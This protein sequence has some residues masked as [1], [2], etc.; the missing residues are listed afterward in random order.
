MRFNKI[1]IPAFGPFTQLEIELPRNDRDFHLFYGPNEAGK[2]S[3]L[4]SLRA[5]LFGI[6]GQSKDVF[7]HSGPQMRIAAELEKQDGTT[8]VFQRRKGNKNTLL[9]ANDTPLAESE[10]QQFLGGVDEAYFDSMFGLGSEELRRGADALLRGEGRL[11]EALFSASLGGTPVDKVI[12]SLEAEAASLFRGRASSII[13]NSAAQLKD[14]LKLS[15]DAITKPETWQA[16]QT[17]LAE[18]SSERSRLLA[19]KQDLTHRKSWLERC[20]D[21]FPMVGQLREVQRQLAE[22]PA[23]PEL[24]ETFASEVREARKEW[25][26]A[27]D[28]LEPLT[29]QLNA[30]ISQ[31][32]S[33]ILAPEVLAVAADIARL[34]AGIGVY[35]EQQLNLADKRAEVAQIRQKIEVA[36]RE[37]EIATP[38]SELETCRISQVKLL[39]L[40]RNATALSTAEQDLRTA[41]E[42]QRAL[43]RE[44]AGLQ[45]QRTLTETSDILEIE[46]THARTKSLEETAKGL[47]ARESTLND[48]ARTLDGLLPLLRVP[49]AGPEQIVGLDV[50]L[51]STIEKFRDDFADL[52]RE[53]TSLT[54][55]RSDEQAKADKVAAEIDH[56]TRQHDLPQLDDLTAARAHRER[57][58]Q[59]LLEDWKGGGASAE[60]VPGV[61]LEQAYPLA[62]AAADDVADRLRSDADAVA[63]LEQHRKESVLAEKQLA[64]IHAEFEQL[65]T[66]RTALTNEW[67]SSWKACGVKPLSAREMLEW[68]DHWESFRQLWNQWRSENEKLSSDQSA[69]TAAVI[70]LKAVLALTDD[71][72]ATLLAAARDR[73]AA[74]HQ[75]MGADL[76]L[77]SQLSNKEAELLTLT[78]TIPDLTA[79]L[80]QAHAAWETCREEYA[81]PGTLPAEVAIG[82]LR[83]RKALF[84]DYDHWRDLTQTSEMLETKVAAYETE[85]TRV[86]TIL[87][88]PC[89]N[90][91]TAAAALSGLLEEAKSSQHRH[92]SLQQRIEEIT[93]A[94]ATARQ[95]SK[96][97]RDALD[98]MLLTASLSVD[99]D[100]EGFL[101][102]LENRQ[103]ISAHLRTLRD[104]LAG[105]ARGESVE[106][107]VAKVEQEN[108]GELDGSL[109][110]LDAQI[111][112]LDAAIESI[113]AELHEANIQLKVI[114]AASDES[115]RQFQLAEFAAARIR[116]DGERFARLQLALGLLRSRID[117]FREQNQ[118]P[119]MEKA[120]RWFAEITGGAFSGIAT[121]YDAGDQPVIAGQR[122]ADVPN[123]TVPVAGL[124]EGTRDQ[125]FLA[126]RLAGLELHLADHEPMPLILDDLLV[127]FDDDRA[128]RTLAAL[129]D[130]GQ[131]TQVLLFTHHAHLVQLAQNEWTSSGFHLHQ[132]S[133]ATH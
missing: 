71:S 8:Q 123:R 82:L 43:E 128:I 23:L 18:K 46:Q 67:E 129:R 33:C 56:F 29:N 52:K 108:A 121:T 100:I 19:E 77:R 119:F 17:T 118:G 88:Q 127:H 32:E 122:A 113:H 69:V 76:T 130:F 44:I 120:S 62:V 27:R 91:E 95:Q 83:S 45:N 104:R 21:A 12:Q 30:L 75:A 41:E 111:A 102:H 115:A 81:L 51:K 72:L 31:A 64:A 68:R 86:A 85:L 61:P 89:K 60:W 35:R 107:F 15:K 94:L 116:H 90:P 98:A 132:L 34:H 11:G 114:E 20:H 74:H 7:L 10:L 14:C 70:E 131:H 24:R 47:A 16:I 13:R 117:R 110:S 40:E 124:S 1:T 112:E 126:L 25:A 84:V 3:L 92:A 50:P 97:A 42:K 26:T 53:L 66:H 73:I 109:T 58:W 87:D 49:N 80:T 101:T 28:R 39:T 133:R 6:P 105:M 4:R 5:F 57:G 99:Q 55:R 78:E 93:E 103:V 65:T 59:L 106:D 38:L 36:C 48:Q 125:L 2:S 22:I 79:K 63:Q 37:L 96:Q 54:K 9:D